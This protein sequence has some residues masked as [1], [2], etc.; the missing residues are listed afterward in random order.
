MRFMS[1]SFI[2]KIMSQWKRHREVV[3]VHVA[4]AEALDGG[5]LWRGWDF[6]GDSSSKLSPFDLL[7]DDVDDFLQLIMVEHLKAV[8]AATITP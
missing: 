5:A 2:I 4:E 8:T 7:G 1:L 3:G 6:D